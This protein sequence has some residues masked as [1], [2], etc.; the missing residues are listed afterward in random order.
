MWPRSGSGAS[1]SSSTS[2]SFQSSSATAAQ[3][4]PGPTFAVVAGARTWMRSLNQGSPAIL[5]LHRRRQVFSTRLVTMQHKVGKGPS[6]RRLRDGVHVRVD[7]RRRRG[8]AVRGV[9]VLEAVA[10]HGDDDATA[11]ELVRSPKES[12]AGCRCGLAKEAL[13]AGELEPGLGDRGVV[14]SVDVGAA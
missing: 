1:S 7:L 5:V 10:G 6:P 2:S 3:S 14:D 11:P 9:R 12:Q 8:M 13:L 4:N